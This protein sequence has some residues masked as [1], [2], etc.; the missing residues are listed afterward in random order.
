MEEA[1]IIILFLA[2]LVADCL[3]C[4][5][6]HRYH[7]CKDDSEKLKD[8]VEHALREILYWREFTVTHPRHGVYFVN[9]RLYRIGEVPLKRFASEDDDYA[10]MCAYEM[11]EKLNETI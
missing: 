1:I 7:M 9:V 11:H 10:R 4:K 3:Y 6:Y 2:F 5:Y 8:A